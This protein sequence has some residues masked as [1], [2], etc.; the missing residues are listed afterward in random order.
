MPARCY[1]ANLVNALGVALCI[2]I[3][4]GQLA[5]P[6]KPLYFNTLEYIRQVFFYIVIDAMAFIIALLTS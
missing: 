2:G 3:A 4:T 5:T 6:E 1:G